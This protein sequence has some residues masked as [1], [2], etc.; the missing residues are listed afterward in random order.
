MLRQ[1]VYGLPHAIYLSVL[2]DLSGEGREQLISQ[3]AVSLEIR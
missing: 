1:A 2:S 3:P